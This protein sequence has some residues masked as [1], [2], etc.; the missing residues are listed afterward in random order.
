MEKI[1]ERLLTIGY[2]SYN[3]FTME[4]RNHRY[5][6]STDVYEFDEISVDTMTV[7]DYVMS[8]H[9]ERDKLYTGDMKSNCFLE[10][11]AENFFYNMSVD[12]C[13]D[14]KRQALKVARSIG[15]DEIYDLWEDK[16]IDV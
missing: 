16:F 3:P 11:G 1:I 15:A 5:L 13:F 12:L 10:I 6:V 2:V 9:N 14:N 4:E 8:K 7:T